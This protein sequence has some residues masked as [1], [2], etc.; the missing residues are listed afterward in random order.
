M[1]FEV[2]TLEE[3]LTVVDHTRLILYQYS[4]M[5]DVIHGRDDRLDHQNVQVMIAF[6]DDKA[7]GWAWTFNYNIYDNRDPLVINRA[8][9]FQVFIRPE[10]RRKGL[11][12]IFY[13]WAREIARQKHRKLI[14]Y[15]WDQSSRSFFNTV[16][17][18]KNYRWW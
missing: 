2:M 6:E 1:T 11:G 12:T 14:S 17:K 10:H 18:Q 15:P 5:D 8:R 4:G 7:A 16:D 3:A 13:N 9:G